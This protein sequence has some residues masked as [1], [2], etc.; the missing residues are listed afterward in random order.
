MRQI[1]QQEADSRRLSFRA[2]YFKQSSHVGMDHNKILGACQKN[3]EDEDGGR[4]VLVMR[5]GRSGLRLFC[6]RWMRFRCESQNDSLEET[7][8]FAKFG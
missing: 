4:F 2:R 5:D 6:Y 1:D 7:G 3:Q 8:E